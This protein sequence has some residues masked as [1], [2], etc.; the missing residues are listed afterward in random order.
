MAGYHVTN[1][2]DQPVWITIYDPFDKQI[3]YGNVDPGKTWP[4]T[5]GFWAI[6]SVYKLRAE[7]PTKEPHSWET[8]TKQTLR[9]TDFDSI[10]LIGGPKGGYWKTP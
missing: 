3:G 7:Y 5:S 10:E 2:T 9:H 4:F 1:S 8:D 6:G